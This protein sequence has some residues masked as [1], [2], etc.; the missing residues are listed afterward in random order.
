MLIGNE[1]IW[2]LVSCIKPIKY[3]FILST[4]IYVIFSSII[5][6]A[7]QKWINEFES[8]IDLETDLKERDIL[9]KKL[10]SGQIK[11]LGEGENVALVAF[12]EFVVSAL[13]KYI[14]KNKTSKIEDLLS[15]FFLVDPTTVKKRK[16]IHEVQ[17]RDHK[18]QILF[19]IGKKRLPDQELPHYLIKIVMLFHL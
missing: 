17:I 2:I 19:R 10:T 5:E 1:N 9:L 15:D 16:G 8:Q 18:L 14:Q 13:L 3:G 12:A 4:M 6:D 7:K 11:M